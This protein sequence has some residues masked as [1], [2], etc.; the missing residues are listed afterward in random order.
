VIGVLSAAAKAAKWETRP[1]PKPAI[2]GLA[3]R[4][5]VARLASRMKAT[6]ATTGI[7]VDI[8]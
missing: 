8:E 3:W 2:A 1:S 7:V 5:V 6:T 4:A